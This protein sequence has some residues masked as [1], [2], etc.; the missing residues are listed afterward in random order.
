MIFYYNNEKRDRIMKHLSERQLE[1]QRN[2]I[3]RAIRIAG[4]Q[5]A[6][7]DMMSKY[8]ETSAS[9]VGNYLIRGIAAHKIIAI[10]RV[11]GVSLHELDPIVYNKAVVKSVL[12]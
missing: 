11:T 1:T 8:T 10:H 5:P 4:S 3:R 9:N 7:A 6:L 12:D 2:A